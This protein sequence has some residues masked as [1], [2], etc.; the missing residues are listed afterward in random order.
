M[1][2]NIVIGF[3]FMC[4]SASWLTA[5]S[6]DELDELLLLRRLCVAL[7]NEALDLHLLRRRVPNS[8]LSVSSNDETDEVLILLMFGVAVTKEALD[9]HLPPSSYSDSANEEFD[10]LLVSIGDNDWKRRGWLS[11]FMGKGDEARNLSIIL[12]FGRLLKSG[13]LALFLSSLKFS[14][15]RHR[16]AFDELSS[17]FVELVTSNKSS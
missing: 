17:K 8:I 14:C 13:L 2:M 11:S 3:T 7:I 4:D 10:K 15:E 12:S 1:L 6:N 9:V 5:V 16:L